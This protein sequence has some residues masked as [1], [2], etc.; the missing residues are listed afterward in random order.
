MI[1]ILY[2]ITSSW[3]GRSISLF[4]SCTSSWIHSVDLVPCFW[5]WLEVTWSPSS[6]PY[7]RWT[8]GFEEGSS[9]DSPVSSKL[10]HSSI[11]SNPTAWWPF[12]LTVKRFFFENHGHG[13][14]FWNSSKYLLGKIPWKSPFLMVKLL[15]WRNLENLL[16]LQHG[17]SWV[18]TGVASLLLPSTA[19]PLN[20]SPFWWPSFGRRGAGPGCRGWPVTWRKHGKATDFGYQWQINEYQMSCLVWHGIIYII[21]I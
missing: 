7:V 16:R 21:I 10:I 11:S 3:R 1:Q 6:A 9:N 17:T 5:R 8:L 12:S 13:I 4:T 20:A 15:T 2:L 19:W 14:L 18:V